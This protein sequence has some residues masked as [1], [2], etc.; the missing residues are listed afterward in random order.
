MKVCLILQTKIYLLP[1]EICFKDLTWALA[2]GSS[3]FWD[4]VLAAVYADA[5]NTSAHICTFVPEARRR[6]QPR[7]SVYQVVGGIK[8]TLNKS[9]T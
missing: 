7:Q 8:K 2:D 4:I 3:F 6:M 9:K 1:R 5:Q